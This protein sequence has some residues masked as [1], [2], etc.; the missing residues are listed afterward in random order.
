MTSSQSPNQVTLD[1]PANPTVHGKDHQ[2]AMASTPTTVI[3]MLNQWRVL[4]E[5]ACDS[6]DGALV[7]A[8]KWLS[9]T[10]S[11]RRGPS[12]LHATNRLSRLQPLAEA[13]CDLSVE[14]SPVRIGR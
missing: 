2:V 8:H 6:H 11:V 1:S 12:K 3:S 13:G 14:E 10:A 5:R 9:D 7:L 4:E